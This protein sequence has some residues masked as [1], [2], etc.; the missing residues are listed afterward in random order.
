[1]KKIYLYLLSAIASLAFVPAVNAQ[2]I[3][4]VVGHD[5]EF[6]SVDYTINN[7]VGVKNW[8]RRQ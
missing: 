7:H 5:L 1:M 3:K 2:T 4:D 8:S 6:K